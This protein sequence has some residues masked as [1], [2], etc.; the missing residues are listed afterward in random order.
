M[1]EGTVAAPAAIEGEPAP[2]GAGRHLY[3]AGDLVPVEAA[4]ALFDAGRWPGPDPLPTKRAA[5]KA[6]K[7]ARKGPV[8]DRAVKGPREDRAK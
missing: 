8:E 2:S 7:R 4:K 1:T 5:R 6:A 3:G